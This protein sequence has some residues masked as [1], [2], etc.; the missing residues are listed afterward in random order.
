VASKVWDRERVLV[1]ADEAGFAAAMG[2]VDAF[3]ASRGGDKQRVGRGD[4]VAP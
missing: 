2:D 3:G 1:D 4:C